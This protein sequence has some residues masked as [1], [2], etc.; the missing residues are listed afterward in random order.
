MLHAQ[1]KDTRLQSSVKLRDAE[2]LL[3]FVLIVLDSAQ[4]AVHVLGSDRGKGECC[5]YVSAR[6]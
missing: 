1:L 4:P 6:T 2:W 5:S 3:K